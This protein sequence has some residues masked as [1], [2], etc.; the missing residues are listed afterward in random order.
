[1]TPLWKTWLNLWCMGVVLF[2]LVLALAAVPG[3]DH[4][5]RTIFVMF[6]DDKA[7]AADF[8]LPSVRF[9]LGLQGALTIGWG[10][11]MTG[12]MRNAAPGN[13]ELWRW[14]TLSLTAWYVIDSAISLSTGF[15]LNAVSNT[16][17][18]VTYLI[19]VL[20]SGVLNVS[21]RKE[22]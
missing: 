2:G 15:S 16:I 4:L 6:L 10:L 20:A 9:G 13:T 22:A 8:D 11:L 21:G 12:V 5:G 1:M 7:A 18:I 19:P 3:A 17:L 14:L